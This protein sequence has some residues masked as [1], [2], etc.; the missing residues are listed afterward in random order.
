M[1]ELNS[2]QVSGLSFSFEAAVA[3]EDSSVITLAC[4]QA[5]CLGKNN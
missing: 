1:Y 2:M 4:E 5:L 3:N